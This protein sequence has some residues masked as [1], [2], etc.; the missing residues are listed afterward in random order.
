MGY[1]AIEGGVAPGGCPKGE[2]VGKLGDVDVWVVVGK[3]DV[4]DEDVKEDGAECRA[5]GGASVKWDGSGDRVSDSDGDGPVGEEGGE[6][7]YYFPW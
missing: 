6:E 5:L 1:V 7:S 4:V 2:V 3:G